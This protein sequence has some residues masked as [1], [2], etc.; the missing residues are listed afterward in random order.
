M[1]A[2]A[3]IAYI[4]HEESVLAKSG[5]KTRAAQLARFGDLIKQGAVAQHR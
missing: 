3:V 1:R 5:K 2:R 4:S